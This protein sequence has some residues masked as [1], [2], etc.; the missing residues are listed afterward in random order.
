[1]PVSPVPM[2]RACSTEGNRAQ[3][4]GCSIPKAGS[5]LLRLLA[6]EPWKSLHN[7]DRHLSAPR[8]REGFKGKDG[9][10][11]VTLPFREPLQGRSVAPSS[12]GGVLDME[13]DWMSTGGM[14]P[15]WLIVPCLY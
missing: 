6:Q 14:E 5:L 15:D 13:R 3:G 7:S 2:M 4:E 12:H 8:H 11:Y 9:A 1:M 10:G